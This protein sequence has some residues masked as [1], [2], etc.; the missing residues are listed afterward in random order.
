MKALKLKL[1]DTRRETL[2]RQAKELT[3][4]VEPLTP[5]LPSGVSAFVMT[6]HPRLSIIRSGC[7][8]SPTWQ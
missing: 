5:T 6:Y 2:R 1:E 7:L 8:R 4:G 3:P